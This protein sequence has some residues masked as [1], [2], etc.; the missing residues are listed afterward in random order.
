[1][2]S[3]ARKYRLGLVLAHQQSGQLPTDLFREIVG[4]VSTTICFQV[5]ADDARRFSREF[6]IERDGE[7]DNVTAGEILRLG[8]GEAW[9]KMGRH[10]FLMH[11]YL[12]RGHGSTRRAEYI[13]ARARRNYGKRAQAAA[14]PP[15][16][17]TTEEKR[18]V[19]E[20]QMLLA[21]FESTLPL[22]KP[23]SLAEERLAIKLSM[24]EGTIGELS[25]ILVAAATYAIDSGE[26]RINE[27]VLRA[28]N[29]EP[30]SERKRRADGLA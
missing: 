23:S 28:I 14:A 29:W 18:P 11:T 16:A 5:S 10:A 12:A 2:L 4:T 24:S 6:A 3:R 21:S 15:G 9:C 8:V 7:I 25:R 26:E 30:P 13:I 20:F 27:K 19:H 17:V 22:R 1:M